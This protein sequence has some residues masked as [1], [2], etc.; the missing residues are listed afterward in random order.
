MPKEPFKRKEIEEAKAYIRFAGEERVRKILSH[1][2]KGVEKAPREEKTTKMQQALGNI[3]CAQLQEEDWIKTM[4][5]VQ[6]KQLCTQF[7]AICDENCWTSG[8][9]NQWRYWYNFYLG[10]IKAQR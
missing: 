2:L 3:A 8:G 4:N 7:A 10:Q 1:L 5:I 6:I 9:A